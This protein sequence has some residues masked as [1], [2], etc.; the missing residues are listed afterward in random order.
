M[1][2]AATIDDNEILQAGAYYNNTQKTMREIIG[3]NI[4]SDYRNGNVTGS[5]DLFMAD[6]K[7]IDVINDLQTGELNW[8]NLGEV[9]QVGD[10]LKITKGN[11]NE[12][13]YFNGGIVRVTNREILYNGET[14]M[15]IEFQSIDNA[16]EV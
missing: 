8:Y 11:D 5:I 15:R 16:K 10:I 2:N 4:T 12:A 9:I 3:Q 6:L 14:F 1:D 7:K 13:H